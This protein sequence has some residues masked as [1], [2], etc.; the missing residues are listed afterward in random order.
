VCSNFFLYYLEFRFWL[1]VTNF[2]DIKIIV[3][4]LAIRIWWK[5]PSPKLKS[6]CR[7]GQNKFNLERSWNFSY[8]LALKFQIFL[9][10][11]FWT[12][13]TLDFFHEHNAL[14]FLNIITI[15]VFLH[16]L[17]K[18]I[19]FSQLKLRFNIEKKIINK[20]STELFHF[21]SRQIIS[22]NPE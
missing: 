21:L 2:F 6:N 7:A 19:N 16:F 20:K 14:L 5:E 17:H 3:N 11:S 13:Q 12:V 22:Q 4:Y 9:Y 10:L 1:S 15:I 18:I 8:E